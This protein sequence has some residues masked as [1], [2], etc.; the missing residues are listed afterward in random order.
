MN[1][2]YKI[3]L[4]NPKAVFYDMPLA[5]L[6]LGSCFDKEKFDIKIIDGRMSESAHEDVLKA[7]DGAICFGTTVLTGRPIEDAVEITRKV[8]QSSPTLTTVW[9]GWH[10]SLFPTQP[11]EEEKSI[12]ISV[13]GQGEI[14]FQEIV[15]SLIEGA[16]LNDIRGICFR[17]KKGEVIKN[18]PRVLTK[19]DEL[20]EVNYE[21]IK[22]EDYFKKKGQF[23]FDFISS[24]G[25]F[26]RCTFCADPYVFGRKFSAISPTKMLDT[27]EKNYKKYRFNSINFQDETFFTYRDRVI[28]MA[29]GLIERNIKIKW[30]ATMRAD[31]GDRLSQEDFNLLAKSGLFRVLVGVESGSQEMMDW[32]KKDIKIEQ[33]IA[34]AEKCKKANIGIQ[35]PF[36]VGFPEESSKAFRNSI[37]FAIKLSNL[38]P[39]FKP[40]IFYYKPYPGTPITDDL[41]KNGYQMPQSM[42]EWSNFDYVSN[43]GPW[44]T[45]ER[46]KEVERLKFYI[47]MAKTKHKLGLPLRW[48]AT[49]RMKNKYFQFPLEQLIVEKVKPVQRLS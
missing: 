11:L 2:R 32:L 5:L 6:A 44:V 40:V 31:Q 19:M 39:E 17:D 23:Q 34:T 16:D 24:I 36:I 45:E 7:I 33:V 4:Y 8:K 20:P 15:T 14:T 1:Q 46:K 47:R 29:E 13:Q 21:L 30:A 18:P 49:K 35:F 38:S 37:N 3:V 25:C 28:E 26:Y 43:S 48:V 10:T 27:F 22:V 12:D 9:G 42:N 41:I